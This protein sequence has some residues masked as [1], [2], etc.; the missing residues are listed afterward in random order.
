MHCSL[1]GVAVAHLTMTTVL[2]AAHP[3][4]GL[5]VRPVHTT[6]PHLV[7]LVTNLLPRLVAATTPLPHPPLVHQLQVPWAV[8]RPMILVQRRSLTM[9]RLLVIMLRPR[10]VILW[11]AQH[12]DHRRHMH[13]MGL[14]LRVRRH[15]ALG[16][17][18]RHMMMVRGMNKGL[19]GGTWFG[20]G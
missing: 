8:L 10:Q 16:Q 1:D 6:R 19:E 12:R 17:R 2:V 20:W 15:Q 18:I 11:I 3:L 5:P 9:R 7:S 13:S 4:G 14:L